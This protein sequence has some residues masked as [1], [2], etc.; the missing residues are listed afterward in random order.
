MNDEIKPVYPWKR[1]M[2]SNRPV[3]LTALCIFSFLYFGL[4]AV[5]FLLGAVYSGF[6]TEAIEQYK[7]EGVY[8]I[9]GI[10]IIFIGGFLLHLLGLAGVV[11]LWKR[12]KKGYILIA[13][14]C[15]TIAVFQ[16]FRADIA[17]TTTTIYLFI[18][19]LFGIF[20]TLTRG[21]Q[22]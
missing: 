12:K 4:I 2:N 9:W 8:S 19:L 5:L 16:L 13:F 21:D 17:L 1:R 10:R 20:L 7:P 22:D 15:L 18:I 11:M 3:I 14:A 6:I